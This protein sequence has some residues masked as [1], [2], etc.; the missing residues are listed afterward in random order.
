MILNVIILVTLILLGTDLLF[1]FKEIVNEEKFNIVIVVIA[2]SLCL[3]L[4]AIC[5]SISIVVL[6]VTILSF[7]Y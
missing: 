3:V 2:G 7:Q 1:M 6:I 4:S 5:Y